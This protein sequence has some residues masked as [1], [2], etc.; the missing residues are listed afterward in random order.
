MNNNRFCVIMAGGIGTRFW[1]KS[2]QSMPKQFLD[3]L[4]TGKS[5]LRH[6]FE[7]F[8]PLVDVSNMLVITNIRY[9]ELVLEHLPELSCDQVLCEPI[10]RNTAPAIAYAAYYLA[11]INPS[12][13]MI[14]TPSDHYVTDEEIFCSTVD[15]CLNFVAQNNVLMTIGI[16][17][18]RPE[19]GYGYIQVS[20]SEPI[21][22]V[23]CFVEKPNREMAQIFVQSGEFMW[24]SGIFI[25]NVTTIV[26]AFKTHLPEHHQLFSSIAKHYA[27]PL[28][29]EAVNRAF[30]DSKAISIDYGIMEKRDV[31]F[32]LHLKP[33]SPNS[34]GKP[35]WTGG[36]SEGGEKE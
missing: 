18:N 28:E 10:G 21:D 23:K 30:S 17:P 12:A 22:R 34:S 24:N 25:W 14:V 35:N 2:R 20:S 4:G 36:D 33:V 6:T 8:L 5:F 7:R 3:I 27:T 31:C 26:E 15:N 19:S 29:A 11:K 16:K 9:K 13:E 32:V 1:P